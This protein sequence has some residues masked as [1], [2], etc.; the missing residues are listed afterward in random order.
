M[1]ESLRQQQLAVE[2]GHWPLSR[3]NPELEKV[4]ENPLVFDSLKPIIPL[5]DYAYNELRYSM[6]A[7][8]NPDRAKLLLKRA[9][10]NLD[11]R[12]HAYEQLQR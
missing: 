6:L 7:K 9:Q 1:E 5:K 8:T 10:E 2:C 3:Y 4:N 11:H 12:W